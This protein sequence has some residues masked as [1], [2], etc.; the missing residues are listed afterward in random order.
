MAL[1]PV[2]RGREGALQDLTVGIP[3]CDDD[4]AILGQALDAVAA[5]PIAHPT[6]VVDMSKGGAIRAAAEDRSEHV[7]YVAFP[8]S[9]GTSDSRNRIVELAETRYLLLLDADA[10]PGPGWAEAM[11]GAFERSERVG[12][13][14]ARILPVWSK[15]PPPLFRSTPALDFLGMLD[16]GPDPLLV[17][18]VMGTSYALDRTRLP[19]ER[20][21]STTVGRR[22]GSLLAAEEVVLALDVARQGLEIWYEPDAVVEHHV[23]LERLNWSWM[24]RRAFVAGREARRL[25][26][27][28]EPLPRKLDG[29]DALFKAAVAPAFLAGLLAERF[30]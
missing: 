13:V 18:R 28:L 25:R 14:G 8:E 1:N 4:P 23:R 22:P 24:M 7:R 16:L 2:S 9:G 15:P 5:E 30:R 27:P 11:R 3:T 12:I 26:E 20:P 21:F 10:V 17:P 29:K 19:S 6:L